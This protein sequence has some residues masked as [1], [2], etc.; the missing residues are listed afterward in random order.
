MEFPLKMESRKRADLQDSSF[1]S[2][3]K[4]AFVFTMYLL[5]PV[6]RKGLVGLAWHRYLNP[7]SADMVFC[8]WSGSADS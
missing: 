3:P 1:I 8:P 7:Y 2:Y 5:M 6:R 4:R